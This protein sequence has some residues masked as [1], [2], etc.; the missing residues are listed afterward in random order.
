MNAR[1]FLMLTIGI[2]FFLHGRSQRVIE[3]GIKPT[4]F[5][6]LNFEVN[7]AVGNKKARYGIFFSYRPSTQDSGLVKGAGTGAAGGYAQPHF[8]KLYNSY[9]V[10]LYQKTYLN[11]DMDLFLETDIFYRNWR[12]KNKQARFDNVEG[13]RFNGM[14]TENEDV[15]GLKVLIGKT[16]ML[17]RRESRLGLY[18]DLYGGLGIRHQQQTFETYDGYVNDIYYDYKKERFLY[19]QPSVQGGVKLGLMIAR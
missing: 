16:Y 17:T 9:T 11:N 4:E 15:Y 7:A 14:R 13:Y 3:F 10:G 2:L 12:F 6:L 8:N 1:F 19:T 5:A 18:F